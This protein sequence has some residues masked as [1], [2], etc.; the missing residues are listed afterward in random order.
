[1]KPIDAG[2]RIVSLQFIC[3]RS[4]RH[5]CVCVDF[6]R[7]PLYT[8]ACLGTLCACSFDMDQRSEDLR[9]RFFQHPDP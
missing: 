3:V 4:G 1:V 5:V 6:K 9:M 2:A 7:L 8:S